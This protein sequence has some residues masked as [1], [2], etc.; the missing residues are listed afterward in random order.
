MR[1]S[2]RDG[3][4]TVVVGAVAVLATGWFAALPG[5][6]TLD[7]TT[8]TIGVLVLGLPVSAA[9]VIPG[10]AG[11][12][13]GSRI[14]LAISSGLGAAAA[15]AAILTLANRTEETLGALVALTIVLWA[16][17]TVRHSGALTAH[18]RQA[19]H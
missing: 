8:V 17:A 5:L 12:I 18:P 19:S 11:L 14:Y 10:F 4:A 7:I 1:M 2:T 15:V 3:V 6:H 13:G 16:A 9:A